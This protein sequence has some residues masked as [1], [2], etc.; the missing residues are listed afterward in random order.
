MRSQIKD[1]ILAL[2][3]DYVIIFIIGCV[4]LL[5]AIPA[6][7]IAAMGVP[8]KCEIGDGYCA[9][10]ISILAAAAAPLY[11]GILAA[12][13]ATFKKAQKARKL[14][15]ALMLAPPLLAS[16]YTVAFIMGG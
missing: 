16:V 3:K 2:A 9:L 14:L 8:G 7:L 10:W 4:G 5:L 13:L 1:R 12:I 6:V 15:Y 11:I